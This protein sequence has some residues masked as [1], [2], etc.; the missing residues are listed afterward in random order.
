MIYDA[1]NLPTKLNP[2]VPPV[3]DGDG[4]D[5]VNGGVPV[6]DGINDDSFEV[7]VV[8]NKTW[9]DVV[10]VDESDVWRGV[11]DEDDM[12]VGDADIC[13][14]LTVSQSRLFSPVKHGSE[15]RRKATIM[16]KCV[17]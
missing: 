7:D 13:S 1:S 17:R 2:S 6:V 9:V 8:F 12:T 15:N 14:C 4:D 5:V 3:V 10:R 16:F 11:S